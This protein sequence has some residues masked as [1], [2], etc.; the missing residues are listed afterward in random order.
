MS[1]I[2]TYNTKRQIFDYDALVPASGSTAVLCV[3][4]DVI[5]VIIE[6]LSTRGLWR[7]SYFTAQTAQNYTI[8]D[9]SEFDNIADIISETVLN[10]QYGYDMDLSSLLVESLNNINT[11]LQE[12]RDAI[13]DQ[14]ETMAQCS[15]GCASTGTNPHPEDTSVACT[16]PEGFDS[17]NLFLDYACQAVNWLTDKSMVAMKQIEQNYFNFYF[18]YIAE[19]SNNDLSVTEVYQ[20][21]AQDL[22][23]IFPLEWLYNMS[24][25]DKT[26]LISSMVDL[27]ISFRDDVQIR[28]PEIDPIDD[29]I[30]DWYAAAGHY[31]D[32]FD[33][34][35][36]TIAQDLFDSSTAAAMLSTF[37]DYIAL[38]ATYAAAQPTGGSGLTLV[39]DIMGKI[40]GVGVAM[41][42][43]VKSPTIAQYTLGSYVCT[44]TGDCCPEIAVLACTQLTLTKFKAVWKDGQYQVDLINNAVDIGNHCAAKGQWTNPTLD[45]GAVDTFEFYDDANDLTLN[46]A[47]P[48]GGETCDRRV[49]YLS[50]VSFT[51]NQ[52]VV[53]CA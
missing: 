44:G 49:R 50:S 35:H 51:I 53:G 26:N 29:V 9:A 5:P 33:T 32:Y 16:T 8:P 39:D 28:Y 22:S 27:Y 46:G 13:N 15:C 19:I 20:R 43:F 3:N 47:Y 11:T 23:S 41:L 24:D 37:D 36:D 10:L 7:S 6:L 40:F 48:P 12:V 52:D 17:Y 4:R 34:N 14:S 18:D 38:A 1:D 45:D 42:P 2:R 31:F 25:N 30:S 21:V